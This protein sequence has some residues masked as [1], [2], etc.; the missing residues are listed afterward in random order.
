MFKRLA[1]LLL[2]FFVSFTVSAQ[3]I[4]EQLT[5]TDSFD[6]IKTTYVKNYPPEIT[7]YTPLKTEFTVEQGTTTTFGIVAS[8][9]E[10]SYLVVKWFI[11]GNLE[12]SERIA[13]GSKSTF[14]KT[15]KE[16]E[17]YNVSVAVTDD[18]SLTNS[19]SWLVHI[20]ASTM[21]TATNTI[22]VVSDVST[23]DTEKTFVESIS[24]SAIEQTKCQYSCITKD[25]AIKN[26]CAILLQLC[27]E[28]FVCANCQCDNSLN[29]RVK[30][31]CTG[32]IVSYL[33][34]DNCPVLK[35]VTAEAIVQKLTEV[36]ETIDL[37]QIRRIN[38]INNVEMA[39]KQAVNGTRIVLDKI[40]TN[41]I[42]IPIINS[43]GER[44]ARVIVELD[45]NDV[46]HLNTKID[47]GIKKLRLTTDEQQIKFKNKIIRAALDVNLKNLPE[48]SSL[49]VKE[50]TDLAEEKKAKFEEL[51]TKNGLLIKDRLA[52]LKVDKVNLEN[53]EDIKNATVIFKIEK[54]LIDDPKRIKIFREDEEKYEMLPTYFVGEENGLFIFEGVSK[55]GLSTFVVF[56]TESIEKTEIKNI[57]KVNLGRLVPLVMIG[58]I[59][60][61]VIATIVSKK[62]MR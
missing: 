60:G 42:N 11:N 23:A 29:E 15:T 32:Q 49:S 61:I 20:V 22:T 24:T 50:V 54:G 31:S 27:A 38:N 62:K 40:E 59:A 57:P 3:L 45:R 4:N 17:N 21:T 18:N 25:E 52:T 9:P 30:S 34:A 35:C 46:K 14:I 39:L 13:S 48:G 5:K 1:V 36:K 53:E 12:K 43:N 16:P 56:M 8:D 51:A 44:V 55:N 41:E 2:F 28:G 6:I 19:M 26:N 33:N 10:G 47:V 7:D 37:G 58:I